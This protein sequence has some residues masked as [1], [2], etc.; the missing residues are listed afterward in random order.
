M[1]LDFRSRSG[2][3]VWVAFIMAAAKN[4]IE[5]NGSLVPTAIVVGTRTN[6]DVVDEGVALD[7]IESKIPFDQKSEA[8]WVSDIK[9]TA[10]KSHAIAIV[11][12]GEAFAVKARPESDEYLLSETLETHDRTQLDEVV[13]VDVEH[14][15]LGSF[16]YMANIIRGDEDKV[17]LTPFRQRAMQ[18]RFGRLLDG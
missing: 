14:A 8:D 4:H 17:K 18:A 6:G 11:T 16:G 1:S 7:P 5:A 2:V 12:I 13:A 9:E 15:T 3:E 10:K